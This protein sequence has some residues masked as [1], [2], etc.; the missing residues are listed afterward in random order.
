MNVKEKYVQKVEEQLQEWK[1]DI[2]RLKDKAEKA[3]AQMRTE[4][5]KKLETIKEKQDAAETNLKQLKEASEES[6]EDLKKGYEEIRD[7]L[8]ESITSVQ[9]SF[10]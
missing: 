5:H 6:W 7:D 9:S 4:Y 1:I 8:K 10:K 3:E 2:D